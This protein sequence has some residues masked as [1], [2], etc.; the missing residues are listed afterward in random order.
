LTVYVQNMETGALRASAGNP[1]TLS[2]DPE[3]TFVVE[4]PEEEK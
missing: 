4:V 1:I 2:F 3:A